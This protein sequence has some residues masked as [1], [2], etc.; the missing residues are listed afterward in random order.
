MEPLDP[1][2]YDITIRIFTIPFNAVSFFSHIG[3]IS[4]TDINALSR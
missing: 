4:E 1:E 3:S 2:Y